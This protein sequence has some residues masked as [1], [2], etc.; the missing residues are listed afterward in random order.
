MYG[1][2]GKYVEI[3]ADT[4]DENTGGHAFGNRWTHRIGVYGQYQPGNKEIFGTVCCTVWLSLQ[5]MLCMI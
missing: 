5:Q 4:V 3:S 1:T 2:Q